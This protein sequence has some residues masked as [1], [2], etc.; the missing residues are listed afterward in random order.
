MGPS[1]ASG[2]LKPVDFIPLPDFIGGLSGA[3]IR[4]IE[5]K[6]NTH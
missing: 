4:E 3:Q 2:Y 1:P 6:S 5:A